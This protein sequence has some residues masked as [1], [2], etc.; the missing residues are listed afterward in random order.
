MKKKHVGFCIANGSSTIY[1]AI[2]RANSTHY[3]P[4][5]TGFRLDKRMRSWYI[6]LIFEMCAISNGFLLR[7]L[8]PIHP[9]FSY[10][11][12][13]SHVNRTE[14]LNIMTIG[15]TSMAHISFVNMLVFKIQGNKI[16][17]K[18][19]LFPTTKTRRK[20]HTHFTDSV[21]CT[22]EEKKSHCFQYSI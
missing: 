10:F 8:L 7:F 22:F 17:I 6:H 19:S 9:V 18:N 4:I 12:K 21:W 2:H 20:K 5:T 3:P 15:N 16:K 14:I 11:E 1:F 13:V